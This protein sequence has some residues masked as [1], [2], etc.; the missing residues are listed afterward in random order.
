[1]KRKRI[2]WMNALLCLAALL[3]ACGG[4]GPSGNV[5]N[6]SADG[7]TQA[8]KP[9]PLPVENA[10]LLY[11][12]EQFAVDLV[13]PERADDVV[14]GQAAGLAVQLQELASAQE[15]PLLRTDA[16]EAEAEDALLIG[17][18]GESVSADLL[19]R[20][21]TSFCFAI[22]VTLD[23]AYVQGSTNAETQQ[24]M[25]YFCDT[26]LPGQLVR[27]GDRLYL[28]AGE[29]Q[30]PEL[31]STFI[32]YAV[33]TDS[34]GQTFSYT[35]EELLRIPPVD[36]HSIM[37][38]ACLD[39]D[40][41]YAYFV[42]R[43]AND[44]CSMVKYDLRTGELMATA[45][46]IGCDHGNDVCYNPDNQTVVVS[47]CTN[48][49]RMVSVFRADTLELVERVNV[50]LQNTAITYN[51]QRR[52]YVIYGDGRF[53]VLDEN[54]DLV[55]NFL[56]QSTAHTS[57]GIHCDDNYI[58]RVESASANADGN[59]IEVYD[60]NG[61][62]ILKMELPEISLETEA[63]FHHGR[64]LYIVCYA[65]GRQ[66]GVLYRLRMDS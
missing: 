23:G 21:S 3:S 25:R 60:W 38:G 33:Q 46:D 13:L 58:Y 49:P 6:G 55:K 12:G 43:D 30:S 52:Q 18:T 63:I 28:R 7:Q 10:L 4:S 5:T 29:Y 56:T 31:D 53:C 34:L 40:G 54:F 14:K 45:K 50:G 47:H 51:S 15:P 59:I 32:S 26:F 1:M 20:L 62:Y 35:V 24:A 57:Q 11:D 9:D 64:D 48:Q 36:S 37:Q 66:G 44:N 2:L 41:V 39:T 16:D 42:L 17:M 27:S 22:G 61:R 8:G 19:E 65:G